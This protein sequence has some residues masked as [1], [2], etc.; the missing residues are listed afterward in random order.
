MEGGKPSSA[1]SSRSPALLALATASRTH[2]A[3]SRDVSLLM[4][5]PYEGLPCPGDPQYGTIVS[6]VAQNMLIGNSS[7]VHFFCSIRSNFVSPQILGAIADPVSL[8][9]VIGGTGFQPVY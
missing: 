4:S 9:G 6:I 5:S 7:F 1:A 8:R 3:F 2:R